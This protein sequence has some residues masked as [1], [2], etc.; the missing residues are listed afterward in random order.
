MPGGGGLSGGGIDWSPWAISPGTAGVITDYDGTLAPIVEDRRRAYPVPGTLEVISALASRLALVAVL[1]GRP[2]AFLE[3]Q[4][5][6]VPGLVLVGLYGLERDEGGTFTQQPAALAWLET[7]RAGA[8]DAERE[9]PQGVEVELKGLT[10]ALHARRQPEAMAWAGKWAEEYA[11]ATGLRA[12]RGRLSVE[13]LPPVGTDKGTAVEELSAGLQAVCFFG[14]DTGDLPAFAALRRLRAAGTRTVAVGVQSPEQPD[15]LAQ[16]VDVLV[17]G[18]RQAV[19]LL[20]AL[21]AGAPRA[22]SGG[23]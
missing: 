4:L 8:R 7:V 3:A 14:D 11:A 21:A 9:A 17:D 23:G 6:R 15:E 2:V 20:A 18:P 1:S 10:F 13:L 22:Q 12:Q 16:A 19:E 5:G